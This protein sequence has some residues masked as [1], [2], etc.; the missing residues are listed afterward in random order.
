MATST[1]LQESAD[2]TQPLIVQRLDRVGE[3]IERCTEKVHE[4]IAEL[5]A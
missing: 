1:D 5:S 2:E 3:R 4:L